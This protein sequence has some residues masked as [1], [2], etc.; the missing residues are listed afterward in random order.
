[1]V[2]TPSCQYRP[3]LIVDHA[4]SS[5]SSHRRGPRAPAPQ[6]WPMKAWE[7]GCDRT[8]KLATSYHSCSQDHVLQCV[9]GAV[10]V[11]VENAKGY[12]CLVLSSVHQGNAQYCATYKAIT[13]RHLKCAYW[14]SLR[15]PTL[16]TNR[17]VRQTY[18]ELI[19]AF[20]SIVVYFCCLALLAQVECLPQVFC[21]GSV[22]CT[23]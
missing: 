12:R 11:A 6:P 10:S 22:C 18:K 8:F 17:T 19:K 23:R 21:I 14:A 7:P 1:M 4:S 5:S 20:G 9:S 13:S 16:S 15:K 3:A 2:C